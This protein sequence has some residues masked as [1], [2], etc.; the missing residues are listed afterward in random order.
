MTGNRLKST[1]N[2]HTAELP[3]LVVVVAVVV[4][5]LEHNGAHEHEHERRELAQE[6]EEHREGVDVLP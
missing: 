5:P 6:H 2:H 4:V 1:H 3:A